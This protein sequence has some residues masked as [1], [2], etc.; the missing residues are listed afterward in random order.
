MVTHMPDWGLGPAL[1]A[2]GGSIDSHRKRIQP[3]LTAIRGFW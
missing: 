2:I 1:T 3:S